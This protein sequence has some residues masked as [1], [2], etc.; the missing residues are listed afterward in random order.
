MADYM[1]Q[2]VYKKKRDEHTN[3]ASLLGFAILVLVTAYF[4]SYFSSINLEE[5]QQSS[6]FPFTSSTGFVTANISQKITAPVMANQPIEGS[7]NITI[8]SSFSSGE[9]IVIEVQEIGQISGLD[10]IA[11]L[12][13][14]NISYSKTK[15]EYSA[16]NGAGTRN[17]SFSSAGEQIIGLQVPTYSNINSIDMDIAA[18]I[19]NLSIDFGSDNTEDW[20]YNGQF[21]NWSFSPKQGAGLDLT[22]EGYGYL[23]GDKTFYCEEIDLPFSID[24]NISA[25]YVQI[26]N[27]GNLM[28]A[29]LSIP[30]GEPEDGWSGGAENCDLPE[31][32]GETGIGSCT[33]KMGYP[34]GGNHL[35]CI[36]SSSSPNET[37]RLYKLP[38]DSTDKSASAYT[39]P[40]KSGGLCS[41][42]GYSDF[43]IYAD[44]AVY[45]KSIFGSINF[46]EHY[47]GPQLP[48][49]A[50]MYYVGSEYGS[51]VYEGVCISEQCSVPVKVIAGSTGNVNLSNLELVYDYNGV[52][53]VSNTFYDIALKPSIIEKISGRNLSKD[54]FI[55]SIPLQMFNISLS[56][57]NYTLSII[58]GEASQT[59]N[60]EVYGEKPK[61]AIE[62]EI[63]EFISGMEKVMDAEGSSTLLAL[64][65]IDIDSAIQTANGYKSQIEMFSEEEIKEQLDGLKSETVQSLKYIKKV[66]G[67]QA[68]A[69]VSGVEDVE[70]VKTEILV[71]YYSLSFY[72]GSSLDYMLVEKEISSEEDVSD[73]VVY[74]DIKGMEPGDIISDERFSEYN[75]LIKW[76]LGNLKSGKKTEITYLIPKHM[77]A[78][79]IKTI[80]FGKIEYVC[81]DG[82]C[83]IDEDEK[84][85][86]EDCRKEKGKWVLLAAII[87]VAIIL[88]MI[89]IY[90]VLLG[91]GPKAVKHIPFRSRQEYRSALRHIGAG[92][93]AGQNE[94]EIKSSLLEKGHNKEQTDFALSEFSGKQ[95]TEN[96]P[97]RVVDANQLNS[98]IRLCM[99]HGLDREEVVDRLVN[100][101]WEKGRVLKAYKEIKH[102]AADE[103]FARKLLLR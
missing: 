39:C 101:G 54:G 103:T 57:G 58:F 100:A 37:A 50:L 90:L 83:N 19:T 68:K 38:I 92:R 53:L 51:T 6:Q 70:G 42:A 32:I 9:Q 62:S 71:R 66:S 14:Q 41:S 86:P 81:G 10:I 102:K 96:P 36:Y 40:R 94:N 21:I 30:S 35:V 75:G 7:I 45:N 48:E 63:D 60:V 74:E 4:V 18:R 20:H 12:N 11:L 93:T 73:A 29:I 5:R 85:C 27:A 25:K 31:N 3:L 84:S 52:E 43:F 95:K 47:L 59:I 24:Y 44:S 33:I 97:S 26:D 28:A 15:E 56:A 76:E 91:K 67:K 87:V 49:F 8:N 82:T 1:A 2:Q 17:L 98:Y 79:H 23:S 65:E 22:S 72:D 34:T 55:L 16:S 88:L 78:N 69:S 77:D 46:R 89:V 64:L 99:E 80:V 13:K 61:P